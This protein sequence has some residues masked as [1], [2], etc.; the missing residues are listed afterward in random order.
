MREY[1]FQ[2]LRAKTVINVAEG[3]EL[4]HICDISFTCTGN[5]L[6][7]IVPARKSIF[8][9]LNSQNTICIPWRNIIKVGEDVILVEL[10]GAIGVLSNSSE[11][12]TASTL[13]NDDE[14]PLQ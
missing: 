5:I 9:S 13:K 10:V 7:L 11:T 4:G 12:P 1:T 14:K 6:G 8:A 3:K 2:E